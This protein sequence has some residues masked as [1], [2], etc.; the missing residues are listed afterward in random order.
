MPYQLRIKLVEADRI[1]TPNSFGGDY[2]GVDEKL[3]NGSRIMNG[4]ELSPSG[5]VTAYYIASTHPGDVGTQ[6]TKWT[7][8][9]K[10][11]TRTGNPN[12]LHIFNGERA[13]QYRGVPFLA[14]VIKT[15]KQLTRYS[16]AELMAAVVNAMF[17]VFITT[18]TGN[19]MGGFGGDDIE[20]EDDDGEDDDVRLGVGTI[21]YLK[22]GEKVTPVQST[23]PSGN[24]ESYVNAVCN[25]I[26]ASLEI[27]PE[28]LLKKFSNNFSASK[29]AMNETWKAFKMRRKW[30]VDDFCQEIYRIWFAEAVSKGRI[31]APGIFV[32]PMVFDA[33]THAKWN[34]PAQGQLDPEK[35]VKAS[36]LKIQNGL[37]TH[38]DECASMNGSSF[39]D[40]VRTLDNEW[41][42]MEG[43]LPQENENKEDDKEE[44]EDGEED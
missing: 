40:N 7:R 38:E 34:G 26:G 2:T 37:S 21:N 10:R 19:D 14:P 35:E 25:Q 23:H 33:Y 15:L 41:K 22:S 24:F 4:V 39:E 8:V 1:S 6:I 13:D 12:I 11:G 3:T 43:M 29:G 30:F 42:L 27:A 32:N 16:E 44:K 5:K 18:E 31:N 36:V 20:E 17:S 9:E 28:I